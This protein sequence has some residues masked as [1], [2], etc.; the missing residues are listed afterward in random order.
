MKWKGT[1][2]CAWEMGL[3]RNLVWGV[4]GREG[5][6]A[7][8][9]YSVGCAEHVH[10]FKDICQG[11]LQ[12]D[13]IMLFGRARVPRSAS[14][15]SS[16]SS[17]YNNKNIQKYLLTYLFTYLLVCLLACLLQEVVGCCC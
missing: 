17:S 3:S 14:V 8:T 12:S 5:G 11:T 13:C 10:Y 2:G 1:M 6:Y 16:S 7:K 15:S 4:R 9:C